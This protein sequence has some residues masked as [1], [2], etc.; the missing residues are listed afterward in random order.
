MSFVRVEGRKEEKDEKGV[1]I[2][3][4]R[5]QKTRSRDRQESMEGSVRRD[6]LRIWGKNDASDVS[7]VC[8]ES[9]HRL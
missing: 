3:K 4:D 5:W 8:G 9:L 7:I 1:C 2:R 6:E